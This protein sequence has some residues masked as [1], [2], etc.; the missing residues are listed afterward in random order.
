LC[1][2]TLP[3]LSTL[4]L[5]DHLTS[6]L[7][8]SSH[9]P[10]GRLWGK[11]LIPPDQLSGAYWWR[12]RTPDSVQ[13]PSEVISDGSWNADTKLFWNEFW[14]DMKT[15]VALMEKNVFALAW[16]PNACSLAHTEYAYHKV[17]TDLSLPPLTLQS[18]SRCPPHNLALWPCAAR[19]QAR[20]ECPGD[21][22]ESGAVKPILN[23]AGKIVDYRRWAW[24]LG[25]ST[26]E[27]TR[28][29]RWHLEG[30]SRPAR[31][32]TVHPHHPLVTEHTLSLHVCS[33]C[34]VQAFARRRTIGGDAGRW[35]GGGG[36]VCGPTVFEH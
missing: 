31:L 21:F 18:A 23:R 10:C 5:R 4:T 12:R 22:D 27:P 34:A 1:L 36:G 9:A 15:I 6:H 33:A 24:D 7:L 28:L 35:G 13:V 19:W 30:R 20:S 14:R 17:R 16:G 11:L 2:L 29:R 32:H 8:C 3:S 26:R 25:P